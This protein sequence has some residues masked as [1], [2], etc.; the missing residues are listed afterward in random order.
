[1]RPLGLAEDA[2]LRPDDVIV[3]VQG[4]P[5]RDLETFRDTLRAHDL[6]SGIRLEVLTNG[7]RR[8]PFIQSQSIT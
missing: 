2:G 6:A 3:G 4:A 7:A 1:V 8:Y 5:I